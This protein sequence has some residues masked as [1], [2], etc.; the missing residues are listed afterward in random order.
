MP[1]SVEP[2][3]ELASLG[4]A[5][6]PITVQVI[7][8][9]AIDNILTNKEMKDNEMKEQLWTI[10]A[11]EAAGKHT[12]KHAMEEYFLGAVTTSSIGGHLP[13]QAPGTR[14]PEVDKDREGYDAW[15][16]A[17]VRWRQ[18][19]PG[20][21]FPI[22]LQ[23][24]FRAQW[25][26]AIR[27]TGGT[28]PPIVTRRTGPVRQTRNNARGAAQRTAVEAAIET[29]SDAAPT[30][31][32]PQIVELQARRSEVEAAIRSADNL[33]ELANTARRVPEDPPL[34]TYS[35]AKRLQTAN[36][37]ITLAQLLYFCPFLRR[38]LADFLL[39][40]LSRPHTANPQSAT[41]NSVGCCT[42]R[43]EPSKTL[44]IP[45]IIKDK[46]VF[47]L[48]DTGASVSII[49]AQLAKKLGLK[50]LKAE[51]AIKLEVGDGS[52]LHCDTVVQGVVLKVEGL[53]IPIDLY[54]LDKKTS[55]GLL[56][57]MSFMS[58]ARVRVDAAERVISLEWQGD[59]RNVR[60]VY[61]GRTNW[62]QECYALQEEAPSFRE[63][64]RI[65]EQEDSEDSTQEDADKEAIRLR[66][67]RWDCA[68]K[69]EALH[70]VVEELKAEF[71]A[72]FDEDIGPMTKRIDVGHQIETTGYPVKQRAYRMSPKETEI[73]RTEIVKMLDKGVIRPAN[74]PWSS[75]VVL[76]A[77]KDGSIRFCVNYKKLNSLTRKDAY[78]LPCPEDLLEQIAGKPLFSTIDLFSGYWQI[79][80]E[81]TAVAKTAF[82]CREG[83]YEFLVMPFG[84]TN[85]P[86]T[87]Q[88]VMD[89][90]LSEFI[91]KFVAVYLDDICIYSQTQDEHEEHLRLVV[92]RLA[93]W[94]LKVNVK[95]SFFF[96]DTIKFLGHEVGAFGVRQDEGKC[97]AITKWKAPKNQAELRMFLGFAGYYRRFVDRFADY[98][99][100]LACLLRKDIPWRWTEQQ[101]GAFEGLKTALTSGQV[102]VAPDFTKPF[103]VYTDASDFAIGASL[104]QG[105]DGAERAIRFYSRTMIA[106][107]RNY[108][109]TDKE[110]L[111]VISALKQ[112]RVYLLGNHF[113]IYTDHQALRQVLN[114]PQ[115]TG[116]RARWIA[117]IMP[118]DFEI[119]YKKGGDNVVAD[120]LSRDVNL[121][122]IADSQELTSDAQQPK[123]YVDLDADGDLVK[124]IRLL[125]ARP[126]PMSSTEARRIQ[127][128]AKRLFLHE[129]DLYRRRKAGGPARVIVS[130][131]E[132]QTVL[133]SAHEGLA[134]FGRK[135]TLDLVTAA[136]WWP[137]IAGDV[138]RFVSG[139]LVCQQYNASATK[140][141]TIEMP[142]G[143]L[144]DRIA[145]DFVGP[146]PLTENGN[147]HVLVAIE[148]LTRWPMARAVTN[149]DAETV[150]KFIEEEVVQQFGAPLTILTDRGTHFMDSTIT[151]LLDLLET[152]HLRTTGYHPQTNGL[153]ERF[154]GT[155]KHAL[156]RCAEES[157]EDWD[158][159]LPSILFAYRV[160][161]NT[162]TGHSPF[163][164]LYG[165]EPRIPSLMSDALDRL[166]PR[167][168]QLEQV[169]Y[170][171]DRL[172]KDPQIKKS[173]FTTSD[174]VLVKEGRKLG[175]MEP[176]WLG[177]YRVARVGLN[178]TYLLCDPDDGEVFRTLTSGD[179]LKRF[180]TQT[181]PQLVGKGGESVVPPD[182][183]A[184]EK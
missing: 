132:R 26:E 177:P 86:A 128:I 18:D 12:N 54:V 43:A 100:N 136:Y 154:N 72:V 39:A 45:V 116:R 77:K 144:F 91:D 24:P 137:G 159:Y 55:Y 94:N 111:A 103:I 148:A 62:E 165:V 174:L 181:P 124:A 184:P 76:V 140:A 90:V 2:R 141:A 74:S 182:I 146:L 135:T 29:T 97:E 150:A 176:T 51:H 145:L 73:I 105:Y 164:L 127:T 58:P 110:A 61:A 34:N 84:L 122:T 143:G 13:G 67:E 52:P 83:T 95:K 85:A 117:A 130:K 125:Q 126:L 175:K 158:L 36:A 53:L 106:A 149:A 88:R 109:T 99:A 65:A 69:E 59:R 16:S 151:H 35:I 157:G 113:T 167:D 31:T 33:A 9:P 80:M 48:M 42:I 104:H 3:Q 37:G 172:R 180:R 38:Q 98:V 63:V 120:A 5:D 96:K 173:R 30:S 50:T 131:G 8:E 114:D 47:A 115:P 183:A 121:K 163:S 160:R 92:Q 32:T 87:F 1:F 71:P 147:R 60:G 112:F 170:N 138:I 123:A 119:K 162:A 40:G 66:E 56:L 70:S 155:M 133:R 6:D 139:C 17:R 44:S 64:S 28:I 161:R 81:D 46:T 78:P 14:N 25:R 153:V 7:R 118:F 102:L 19:N 168:E 11:T 101:Q 134:H 27:A 75:P 93:D 179:R 156:A 82:V 49:N 142:I 20:Q 108:S 68:T 129:G 107:E 23:G 57:G 89:S 4:E 171:R 166:V 169:Q 10:A 21:D 22:V 178:D 79:P 15:V 152:K 41:V